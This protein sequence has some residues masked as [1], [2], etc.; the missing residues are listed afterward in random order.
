MSLGFREVIQAGDI[1]LRV[2]C[3]ERLFK[4]IPSW[5]TYLFR[6]C[7]HDSTCSFISVAIFKVIWHSSLKAVT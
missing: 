4:G 6:Q 7:P 3:M 5:I 2:I 1:C